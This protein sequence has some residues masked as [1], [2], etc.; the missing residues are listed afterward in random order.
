MSPAVKDRLIDCP[1]A[2]EALGVSARTVDRLAQRG[3]LTRVKVLGATRYRASQI[4]EIIRLW[5][6]AK[7]LAR[8]D[9]TARKA[10]ASAA[11]AR[12]AVLDNVVA[13]VTA[14]AA[15]QAPAPGPVA[16]LGAGATRFAKFSPDQWHVALVPGPASDRDREREVA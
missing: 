16:L 6:L 15:P 4:E 13:S 12:A 10:G 5:P 9:E 8:L 2:A 3:I 14:A 1:E 7:Q 11:W